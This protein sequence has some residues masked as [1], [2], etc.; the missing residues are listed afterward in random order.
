MVSEWYVIF[1]R[2]VTTIK[3]WVK[4]MAGLKSQR[5]TLFS[6]NF[7]PLD[8]GST[9]TTWSI[10]P[11]SLF[12]FLSFSLSHHHNHYAILWIVNIL[13]TFSEGCKPCFSH[14]PSSSYFLHIATVEKHHETLHL[15]FRFV[16]HPSNGTKSKRVEKWIF[17]L[18]LLDGMCLLQHNFLQKNWSIPN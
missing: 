13:S 1:C 18:L 6:Y 11:R 8:G 4:K 7:F 5:D 17:S 3:I 14:I 16:R 15:L 10:P 2:A 9:H 12:L